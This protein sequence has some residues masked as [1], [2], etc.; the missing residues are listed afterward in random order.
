MISKRLEKSED[1]SIYRAL[2]LAHDVCS[3]C[4]CVYKGG[5]HCPKYWTFVFTNYFAD[6]PKD[7]HDKRWDE[8][9]KIGYPALKKLLK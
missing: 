6:E 1:I 9:F 5:G 4:D 3:N 2:F 8:L 7:A